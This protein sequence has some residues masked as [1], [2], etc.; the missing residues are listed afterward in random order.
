VIFRAIYVDDRAL[1][2]MA[3]VRARANVRVCAFRASCGGARRDNVCRFCDDS[4]WGF[5]VFESLFCA[6]ESGLVEFYVVSLS[7]VGV[8]RT[9]VVREL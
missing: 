5:R 4:G 1:R 6:L 7:A 9:R 2:S 3:N 8:A